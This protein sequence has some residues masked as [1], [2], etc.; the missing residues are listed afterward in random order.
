LETQVVEYPSRKDM[1]IVQVLLSDGQHD[2]EVECLILTD[3]D[4]AKSN[5]STKPFGE[6]IV[7]QAMFGQQ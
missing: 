2:A 5:H 4:V 7:D 1:Q 6:N 3:G